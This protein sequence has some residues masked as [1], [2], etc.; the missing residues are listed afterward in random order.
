MAITHTKKV[1][2]ESVDPDPTKKVR[3][4]NTDSDKKMRECAMQFYIVKLHF[5]KSV[6]LFGAI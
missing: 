1:D 5:Q 2:I 4:R 3:I 6:T